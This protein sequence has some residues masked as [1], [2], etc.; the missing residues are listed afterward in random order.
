MDK[1]LKGLRAAARGFAVPSLPPLQEALQG[2]PQLSNYI[3]K[4]ALG[5]EDFDKTWIPLC[6]CD[7]DSVD[8]S[9]GC[10]GLI[11][12]NLAQLVKGVQ[13]SCQPND[14]YIANSTILVDFGGKNI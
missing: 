11:D 3:N 6:T 8:S 1:E 12:M 14:V 13:G 7:S 10:G 2:N 4:L 5:T 9:E